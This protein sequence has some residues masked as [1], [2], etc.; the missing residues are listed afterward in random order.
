MDDRPNLLQRIF[1]SSPE[2]PRTS[3]SRPASWLLDLFVKSKSGATVNESSS[4]T[5]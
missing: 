5:L 4:M 3:L 2:N 1:R